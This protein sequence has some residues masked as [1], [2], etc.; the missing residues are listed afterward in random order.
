MPKRRKLPAPPLVLQPKFARYLQGT[1]EEKT[2]L[3][4]AHFL[5]Q[6]KMLTDGGE[7][8]LQD[9]LRGR[10]SVVSLGLQD[11]R[12]YA[13]G[14]V[15]KLL[16]HPETAWSTA[17]DLYFETYDRGKPRRP[18]HL[19][20]LFLEWSR[21]LSWPGLL[22]AAVHHPFLWPE[23]KLALS[24]LEEASTERTLLT[25]ALRCRKGFEAWIEVYE[26]APEQ[27][28]DLL[29]LL[30][31]LQGAPPQKR[32][33][34]L[35]S[36]V[37][38]FTERAIGRRAITACLCDFPQARALRSLDFKREALEQVGLKHLSD[39]EEDPVFISAF[40]SFVT[41]PKTVQRVF[42]AVPPHSQLHRIVFGPRPG[43]SWLEAQREE[44]LSLLSSFGGGLL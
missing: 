35:A 40:R 33:P 15:Q 7:Q 2:L 22:E 12:S 23:L 25:L 34:W 13:H 8:S 29:A 19:Q 31:H 27:R 18:T 38:E 36:R 37:E 14:L 5:E 20:R 44:M 21:D 4:L 9:G 6:R 11:V 3:R 1:E 32:V 28:C 43:R 16:T 42:A 24:R 10:N 39:A 30:P 41:Q 26:T 17:T